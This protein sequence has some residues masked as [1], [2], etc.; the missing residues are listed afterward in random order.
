MVNFEIPENVRDNTYTFKYRCT[1]CGDAIY[2]QNDIP[3]C[4]VQDNYW[5]GECDNKGYYRFEKKAYA[6]YDNPFNINQVGVFTWEIHRLH[7]DRLMSH[8]SAATIHVMVGQNP[9]DKALAALGDLGYTNIKIV[10]INPRPLEKLQLSVV[11]KEFEKVI[12]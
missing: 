3:K 6:T 2:I 5:C 8:G 4:H 11:E 12:S 10:E 7:A 1:F 9:V